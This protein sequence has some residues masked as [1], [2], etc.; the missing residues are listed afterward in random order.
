[1]KTPSSLPRMAT[2][3]C[4]PIALALACGW[5]G[6]AHA[7][8]SGVYDRYFVTGSTLAGAPGDGRGAGYDCNANQFGT[9]IG[10]LTGCGINTSPGA[11]RV[12]E[13]ANYAGTTDSTGRTTSFF[14]DTTAH[15]FSYTYDAQNV[16]HVVTD[17]N[18]SRARA[19]ADLADA[20]LHASVTNN[21][22]GGF[23]DGHARA[24]LHDILNFNV[25]GASADTVTR[26][27]FQFSIDG[28]AFDNGQT[29]IYGESG[30]GGLTAALRLDDQSSGN[31][32][33]PY[34]LNATAGWTAHPG[35]FALNT[36]TVEDRSPQAT[37]GGSWT[38]NSFALM[39]FNGYF[40]IIGT[41]ATIN[42]TLSLSLDCSI[43]LQCDYYN[44]ARF[45]FVGLPSSVSFTSDSGVFLQGTTVPVP[46]PGTYALMLAGLG[47]VGT[48]VRRR[49]RR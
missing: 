4:T 30:S 38:T 8:P 19:S 17:A 32:N 10:A 28:A 31:T 23:V 12:S 41:Q 21:T 46:E 3:R 1:M 37:V 40:D 6:L 36:P 44:T 29:T 42:P 22:T 47:L 14:A 7:A 33:S 43:G 25:A 27:L 5:A 15:G 45:S 26:V 2:T 9:S 34:A 18:F 11:N 13:S 48:I 49:A 39:V 16:P 20:S 24:D 35:A